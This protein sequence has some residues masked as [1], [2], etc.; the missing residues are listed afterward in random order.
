MRKRSSTH[1]HD[2]LM[3]IRLGDHRRETELLLDKNRREN[4]RLTGDPDIIAR[5][6]PKGPYTVLCASVDWWRDEMRL[7]PDWGTPIEDDGSKFDALDNYSQ[8]HGGFA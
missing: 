7:H 6:A 8:E 2:R 5:K 4:G 3:W 1:R